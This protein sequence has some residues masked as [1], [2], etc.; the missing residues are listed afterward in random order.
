MEP[1]WGFLLIAAGIILFI[2]G[3]SKGDFILC[4]L[5]RHRSKLLFGEDGANLL[6]LVSGLIIIILGI[7]ASLGYLW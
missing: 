3:L 5:L 1:L 7:L 2:Y 6:N 4:K